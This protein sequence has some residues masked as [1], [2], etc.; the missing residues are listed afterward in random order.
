MNE[1]SGFTLEAIT[2]ACVCKVGFY[3][4]SGK[5]DCLKCN[6]KCATCE[7]GNKCTK[8]KGGNT[9]P[10]TCECLPGFKPIPLSQSCAFIP[11]L[12]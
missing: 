9:N 10:K 3:I 8:C 7:N 12:G 1:V 4:N 5:T 11:I 6:P 2:N